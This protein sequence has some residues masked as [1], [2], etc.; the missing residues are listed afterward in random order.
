MKSR[1]SIKD[2]SFNFT[3]FPD[4]EISLYITAVY[5]DKYLKT[6]ALV[7][8]VT[9]D[10]LKTVSNFKF[11]SRFQVRQ[12]N[13]TNYNLNAPFPNSAGNITFATFYHIFSTYV[14]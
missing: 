14:L 7:K 3:E 8:E 5:F 10:R 1:A 4:N 13:N 6:S 11:K 2:F 9:S 12:L